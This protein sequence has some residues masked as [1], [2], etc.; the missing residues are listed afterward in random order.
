MTIKYHT[1]GAITLPG[2]YVRTV[3]VRLSV[4]LF[5]RGTFGLYPAC[6]GDVYNHTPYHIN[7][8]THQPF[9]VARQD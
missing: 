4:L 2:H 3:V 7:H 8:L 9:K 6:T 5:E 1:S